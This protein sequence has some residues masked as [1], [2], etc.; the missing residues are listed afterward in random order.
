MKTLLWSVPSAVVLVEVLALSFRLNFWRRR[1]DAVE[2]AALTFAETQDERSQEKLILS[3]ALNL[4]GLVFYIW[5]ILVLFFLV[6]SVFPYEAELRENLFIW[7]TSLAFICYAW[8]RASLLEH[9]AQSS[10]QHNKIDSV[11]SKTSYN[12]ISRWLHWMALEIGIVRNAS[13]ELEKALFL[14]QSVRDPSIVDQPVYVMG[15]ARSGTT[16]VL[17]ILEKTGAFHSP[18]YRN[19][20]FVLSPNLWQGL[21][22]YSQLNAQK[23][24][25][26]HDD[27]ILVGFDSPESFEEVFWQTACDVKPGQTLAYTPLSEEILND[28]AAY[29]LLSTLSALPRASSSNQAHQ[30][31]RYLSKNNNNVMRLNEISAQPGSHLVLIIR[32]PLATAWSLYSQ[33]KRFTQLQTEDAFVRAYMRWLGHLEFGL[34]H[35]PLVTGAKH[36]EGLNPM[37]P[38]YWLAYWLSIYE[39]I[40]QTYNK[41]LH[42]QQARIIVMSHERMCEEPAQELV[43]LFKFLN[44]DQKVDSYIEMLRSIEKVDLRHNFDTQL[45]EHAKTLQDQILLTFY[46]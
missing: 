26:A 35:K 29:R 22:K 18:T 16:V 8:L 42:A 37:Q 38:D 44:I 4:L 2:I 39:Y 5:A 28:F 30:Q 7:I 40:W 27:G 43:K 31:L 32:D 24:A 10:Q 11:S 33:H 1:A 9:H 12:R 6:L 3:A 23:T 36:L 20:P 41:L 21:T 45:C 34:G 14:N 46:S 17:E 25:R 13:F 15:L 19:M